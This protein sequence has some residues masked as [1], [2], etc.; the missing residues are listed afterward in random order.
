MRRSL[1][2]SGGAAFLVTGLLV[3]GC[4]APASQDGPV[5]ITFL[6]PH[7]GGYDA[8]IKNFEAANPNIRVQQQSVPFDQLIS[9]TQARLGAKDS[10][11][12]VVSV[13]PPRL[14]D[15]AKKGF[16][17]DL[18]GDT[19]EMKRAFTQVGIKAVTWEGKPWAYP[20]WTSDNFLFFNKKALAAA[21]V[22]APGS[23]DKDRMT[24]EQV[25][26][27]AAKVQETGGTKYGFAIE[28]VDRYYALQPMLMS[29]GAGTGLTGDGNLTPQVNSSEWKS[30]G[31][32]YKE[33]YTSGVSP[34]GVDP[35]QMPDLFKSGQTAFLLAGPTRIADF[36]G[37][38]IKDE[39]G[40]APHPYFTGKDIVTP[41][42]SWAI[43]VSAYS[44][45]QDA[46]Q[47]FA[48]FAT[49]NA[50]GAVAASSK[51][52]LPPVNKEAFPGY[53]KF[54]GS[55][56]PEATGA[57]PDLIAVDSEKYAQRRPSTIGYVDFETTMNKSFADIRN[58]GDVSGILDT[59][60]STLERQM[61]RHK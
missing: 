10:T 17:K 33:L 24:W 61:A 29:M 45:H 6:N 26:T 1:A 53:V 4:S 50:E 5:T 51:M 59:A 38:S 31:D 15:M 9:Q 25:L 16:L 42:D 46:A 11:I 35:A 48:Q 56:A 54:L 43:G 52:N 47:K 20:L 12:D 44:K 36:Q 8:V 21:G 3:S 34:K 41:T 19:D 58:G 49:L 13:D 7:A 40:M 27:A 55:I 2:L 30:F 39:W 57:L 18:S 14:P 37:S 28:Q 22:A 60:Q 23:S 32:W